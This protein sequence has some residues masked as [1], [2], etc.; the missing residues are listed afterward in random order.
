MA[1]IYLKK[2]ANS[3]SESRTSIADRFAFWENQWHY[4]G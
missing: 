3:E 2:E 1:A 4:L